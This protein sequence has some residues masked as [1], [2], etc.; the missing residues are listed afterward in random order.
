[1]PPSRSSL[2][3]PSRAASTR[4]L[5]CR[6]PLTFAQLG[7][8][9]SIKDKKTCSFAKSFEITYFFEERQEIKFAVYAPIIAHTHTR[10]HPHARVRAST[11][12]MYKHAAA[13]LAIVALDCSLVGSQ[14]LPL[15]TCCTHYACCNL[16]PF[17]IPSPLPSSLFPPLHPPLSLPAGKH[18][19]TTTMAKA[20]AWTHTT[21]SATSQP[22]LVQWWASTVDCLQ[23]YAAPCDLFAQLL[24]RS[25]SPAVPGCVYLC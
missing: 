8:T 9:E 23:R 12:P 20:K 25:A 4:M 2:R 21:L 14:S 16:S 5:H 15:L 1:M 22:P 17:P 19:D 24:P 10:N 11:H 3:F 18:A 7:R 13:A 6:A